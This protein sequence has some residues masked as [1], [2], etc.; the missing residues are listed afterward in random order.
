M[1]NTMANIISKPSDLTDSFD[2]RKL[3]DKFNKTHLFNYSIQ[4]I[5]SII[6]N[7]D[8]ETCTLLFWFK[9]KETG[10]LFWGS[11]PIS[12]D[13]LRC[14]ETQDVMLE[15]YGD[16]SSFYQQGLRCK[17]IGEQFLEEV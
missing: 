13:D 6:E 12:K 16:N 17:P 1:K 15:L 8:K 5:R 11:Y 7:E 4:E 10:E 3:K 14:F 9:D 2:L